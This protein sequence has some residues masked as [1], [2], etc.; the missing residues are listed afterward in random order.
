LN[1]NDAQAKVR[2]AVLYHRQGK[3]RE[4]IGLFTQGIEGV[5]PDPQ[6]YKQFGQVLLANGQPAEAENRFRYSIQLDDKDPDAHAGLAESLKKMGQS[7]KAIEEQKI[8][9]QLNASSASDS[10]RVKP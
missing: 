2:L 10:K 7:K 8:A 5:K 4:S 6:L 3:I 9:D 1:T